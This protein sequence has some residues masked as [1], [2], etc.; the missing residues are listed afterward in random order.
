MSDFLDVLVLNVRLADVL[1][2]LFITALLYVGVVWLKR[3]AARAVLVGLVSLGLAYVLARVLEMYLVLAVFRGGLTLLLFSLVV[4]YRE[5]I[6][7]GLERLSFGWPFGRDPAGVPPTVAFRE[8]LVESVL[9]LAADSCGALIVL[10]GRH[11]LERHVRGGIPA[12]AR[13]SLPLVLSI[14]N[15]DTPGHDGAVVL[16]GGLITKFGVH[17]PLSV[18]LEAV[19]EGGTRHTAALGLAERCDA[20]V[21]VVSEERGT[22][23]VALDGTLTTVAAAADLERVLTE[24]EGESA[25]RRRV[26][27]PPTLGGVATFTGCLAAAVVLWLAFAFRVDTVRREFA[28]IPVEIRNLPE[29]WVVDS[30]DPPQVNV[31]LAGPERAMQSIV[32]EELRVAFEIVNRQSGSEDYAVTAT[33]LELP[34]GIQLLSAEPLA[35]TIRASTFETTSLPVRVT[36]RGDPP[37]GKAVS[38]VRIEPA[39]VEVRIS[40]T[41]QDWIRE[42]ATES[43]DVSREGT[44]TVGLVLPRGVQLG[45]RSKATV[46]VTVEHAPAPEVAP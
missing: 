39:E 26:V 37:A 28:G 46:Q 2:V 35:V 17:L 13:L 42:L 18:N 1:D 33:S 36:R 38:G 23:S 41:A 5:D 43:V 20:L 24:F 27:R 16:E 21:I 3:R 11:S 29:S 9:A 32:R 6:R 10:R 34:D 22:I 31:S 19:G 40:E 14:F 7:H 30:V 4:V 15:H 12:D 8:E 25:A 45:E 44:R